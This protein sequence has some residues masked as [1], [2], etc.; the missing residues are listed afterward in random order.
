[1]STTEEIRVVIVDDE[2][3]AREGIRVQIAKYPRARIV[4]ECGDGLQAVTVIEKFQ[5]DVVFLD[6]QMPGMDGFEVLQSLELDHLPVV[7]FVTAFDQY[8]LQAFEVSAIDYL[9]KPFTDERFQKAFERAQ[10]QIDHAAAGGIDEHLR[11]LIAAAQTPSQYIE[12]I[13]VK[14]SGRI[15]F[16]SVDEIDW[17]EAADNYVSLHAGVHAH[18]VRDTLTALE[19]KLDPRHFV[20]LRSSAIVNIDRIKELHPLFKGEFEVLM[21]SGASLRT[22]RRYR[23][24]LAEL[25][26]GTVAG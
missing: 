7:V 2:P 4:A 22:S 23:K 5:P 15:F 13:V 3:I 25:L 1:M 20:R 8:A 21:K 12:R 24:K 19:A 14:T 6:V 26:N 16:L 9:L 17:I 11:K 10:R 18:L